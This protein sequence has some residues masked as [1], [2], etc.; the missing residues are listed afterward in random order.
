MVG[1]LLLCM[2][3]VAEL[4]SWTPSS[5]PTVDSK[6]ERMEG[7]EVGSMSAE[8]ETGPGTNC[9]LKE[10]KQ[11]EERGGEQREW[12][13][14]AAAEAAA[15]ACSQVETRVKGSM[16]VSVDVSAASTE[17][18]RDR[19]EEASSKVLQSLRHLI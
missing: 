6:V 14:E 8:A 16:R 15:A 9:F 5:K 12:K 10:R 19:A 18:D 13:E 3:Q 11:G 2:T 4:A 17:G 7:A 1:K